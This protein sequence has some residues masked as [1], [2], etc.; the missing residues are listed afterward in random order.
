MELEITVEEKFEGMRARVRSAID[1]HAK[2]S[3][4]EGGRK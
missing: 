4:F 3:Q 1:G 2:E